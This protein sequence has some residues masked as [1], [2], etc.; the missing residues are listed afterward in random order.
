MITP[1]PLEPQVIND[2]LPGQDTEQTIPMQ[3]VSTGWEKQDSI[4]PTPLRAPNWEERGLTVP[5]GW[6]MSMNRATRDA[7]ADDTGQLTS[8]VLLNN[9]LTG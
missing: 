3:L 7:P 6:N 8:Q 1:V 9:V 5:L 4:V 2:Q